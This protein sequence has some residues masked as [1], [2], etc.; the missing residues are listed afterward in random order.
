[1]E[2]LDS[3]K[4]LSDRYN[5]MDRKVF[6]GS[7]CQPRFY[8]YPVQLDDFLGGGGVHPEADKP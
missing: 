1:M 6:G 4:P 2:A 8:T 3:S 5:C 7:L